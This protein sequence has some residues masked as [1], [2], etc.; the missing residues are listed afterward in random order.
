MFHSFRFRISL[1]FGALVL[2]LAVAL[3][4]AVGS[5]VTARLTDSSGLAL[6]SLARSVASV[7]SDGMTERMRDVELLAAAA[8]TSHW[9]DHRAEVQASL[10][11]LHRGGDGFAWLGIAD[12]QGRVGIA[13]GNMLVGVDVSNRRWFIAA[14]QGPF[15]GDAHPAKL[16][17]EFLPPASDGG[18]ARFVDFAAPIRGPNGE[19]R[20]VLGAHGHWDW[21]GEVIR[22][23]RSPAVRDRGV[24]VF[25]V[26]R[27]GTAIH[28]PSDVAEAPLTV[29]FGSLLA[30]P[31]ADG[32]RLLRWPDGKDY[33]TAQTAV[34]DLPG[35]QPLGWTVLVRQPK[36]D[37]LAVATE[38]RWAVA[39]LGLL[40]ALLAMAGAWMLAGRASRPLQRLSDVALRIEAG[41][42]ALEIPR[43]SGGNELSR[44]SQA[45]QGMTDSLLRGQAELMA[46]NN[47]LEARVLERTE[48]LAAANREL[49]SLA[50]R[51]GLT[52]L[53]NRRCADEHLQTELARQRRHGKSLSLLLIDID[54][55]KRINDQFGHA[56]GDEAL[57]AVA[58]CLVESSRATDVVARFGGEEFLVLLPETGSL[59]A[60]HVAEKL[61][62]EVAQLVLPGLPP[63]TLSIGIAE[64]CPDQLDASELAVRTAARLLSEADSALYEAKRGGRNRSV[65]FSAEPPQTV[66]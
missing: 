36:E 47:Q 56:M 48:A 3:S 29:G 21:V 1:L 59:A 35:L 61:R 2:A 55:F 16:L 53:L 25:I 19:L 51:D 17:A 5:L 30:G 63:I 52:G 8:F 10:A 24:R 28:R 34:A 15:V 45:M 65:V 13:T 37:A 26:D 60:F 4:A 42:T 9:T 7:L 57:R 6:H 22:R 58:A 50:R 23:M 49:E 14:L 38:A 12:T 11:R 40:G 64:F 41:E 20:G 54:H 33:L 46:A 27:T 62:T 31:P 18:P 39:G 44:L 66:A 43:V 32:G